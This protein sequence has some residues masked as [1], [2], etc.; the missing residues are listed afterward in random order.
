VKSL[1]A[2]VL[3][4]A[5]FQPASPTVINAADV[6]GLHTFQDTSTGRLW[7]DLDLYNNASVTPDSI[8]AAAATAGFTI[9][10]RADVDVLLGSLPL[11]AGAFVS[12][13]GITGSNDSG[14]L[15]W[16]MYDDGDNNGFYGYAYAYDSYSTWMIGD[17]R[18]AGNGRYGNMGIFAYRET[19]AVPEPG[20]IA[21]LGLGLAGL[22]ALRRRR[23]S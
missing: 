5:V 22:A 21:L 12:Y 18:A 16:G 13:T 6:N 2:A 14:N 9:A 8:A 23:A 11:N 7:L 1:L 17:N 10:T 20:S 3:A 4:L 15:I 19:A